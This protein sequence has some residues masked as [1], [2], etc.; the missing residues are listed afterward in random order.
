MI[1]DHKHSCDLCSL[2]R[3]KGDVTVAMENSLNWHC[4]TCGY[5][6]GLKLKVQWVKHRDEDEE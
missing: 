2:V 4:N 5:W 6:Y 1:D 3:Q